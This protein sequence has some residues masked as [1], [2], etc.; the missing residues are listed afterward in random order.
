MGK[1]AMSAHIE[2]STPKETLKAVTYIC[3]KEFKIDH[4]AIQIEDTRDKEKG[5]T[6]DTE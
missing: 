2:T 6:C 1:Y 5:F 4:L 3:K